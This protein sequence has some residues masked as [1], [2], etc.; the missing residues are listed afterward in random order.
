LCPFIITLRYQKC[1]QSAPL[2]NKVFEEVGEW[3]KKLQDSKGEFMDVPA[4][5]TGGAV[6]QVLSM[7]SEDLV[8]H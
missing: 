2:H 1:L 8:H 7:L 4:L 5:E 3:S 6:A